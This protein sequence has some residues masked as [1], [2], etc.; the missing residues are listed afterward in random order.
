M[1]RRDARRARDAGRRAPGIAAAALIFA[2]C[3]SRLPGALAAPFASHTELRTAV[4]N[5]LA[6][7]PSGLNCCSSGGADCGAAGS[8]DMPDW[9]TSLVT[10]MSG[11]FFNCDGLS[12]SSLTTCA[13]Y[14]DSSFNSKTFNQDISK[15]NTSSVAMMERMF[16]GAAAFNQPIGDWDT[17]SVT[18][19]FSMFTDAAAFN[20]DISKW[21]TSS[22]TSM[23]FMFSEATAFNQPIGDWDTASVT[24][25]TSMFANAVAFNQPIGS[26]NTSKVTSMWFMFLGAS[27][28]DQH[29]GGW[30]TTALTQSSLMFY[31]ATAWLARYTNCGDDDSHS[32]CGEFTAAG[33]SYDASGGSTDGPPG[34]WVRKE[35]AC[36]AAYGHPVGG[37][38][39][40]CTDTLASG[41]FCTPTCADGYTLNGTTTSCS[42]RTLT[43]ATCVG[44]PCDASV[45]ANGYLGNC[46]STLAFAWARVR[47]SD[48]TL[49]T[50]SVVN[51]V[52]TSG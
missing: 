43:R 35:N 30:D 6:A 20:Q 32:A 34:A 39:G 10:D 15:W 26:W 7:V 46:S 4:R 13:T 31:T 25:M 50:I 40:T 33:N 19:M 23:S 14:G 52:M 42:D 45:I 48:L 9:D 38:A 41:S 12:G 17:S 22:V 2:V 24:D 8:V 5:C 44:K 29:I 3:G 51:G 16:E 27:S 47:L 18:T 28:F 37:S 11:T 1:P 49:P 36:D 21:N